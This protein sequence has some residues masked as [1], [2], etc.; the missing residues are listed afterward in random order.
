MNLVSLKEQRDRLLVKMQE[1]ALKGFTS[2]SRAQFDAMNKDV[3]AL[4]ADI[5]RLNTIEKINKEQRNAQSFV[6]SPR[7]PIGS[8]SD[9]K[10]ERRDKVNKA[11]RSYAIHGWAGMEREQRDLLTTSDATGGAL[12]PQLFDGV[13]HEALK[14]Y[15]PIAQKVAQRQTENGGAPLKI[16]ISN[17]TSNGLVLLATE[18]SSS[19]AETDPA[20]QSRIVGVD[21]VTGGLVKVSFQ[22]L[23]DSAF[24][25]DNFIRDKF[26][27]R[28]ARGL[29]VAITTGKDSAGTTLPNQT[30][31]GILGVATV[32]TTTTV[33]A[34]GIG[35]SDITTAF[36][37][38]D[39]AYL[40]PGTAWVFNTATRAALLGMKDGFGRPFWIP[41]PS[42]DGPF[43]KLLGYDV[44]LNQSMPNLGVAN[45]TPILFGDLSRAYLLRSESKPSILRL[46]ERYADTLEVGFFLYTRVGGASLVAT[47]APSPLVSIKLAAS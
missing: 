27:I 9:S 41:D 22:E 4:D 29:E 45:A 33:L 25:L 36:G 26:S 39:A 19:P 38:V 42:A 46:N 2:E 30:A 40:N 28:Y 6:P 5:E 13:L 37:A 35:W 10:E 43:G 18:G 20:F 8:N 15:G 11:F 17:D 31:G 7:Q 21:T 32:G 3:A 12:I 34:N 47:G 23:E 44:V 14:F 1:I 16:S 24:D